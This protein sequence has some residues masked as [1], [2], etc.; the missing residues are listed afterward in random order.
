MISSQENFRF[1]NLHSIWYFF[2]SVCALAP[3]WLRGKIWKRR[4]R[5]HSTSTHTSTQKTGQVMNGGLRSMP[6]GTSRWFP[7]VVDILLV[8]LVHRWHCMGRRW[9]A[10]ERRIG[11]HWRRTLTLRGL[12]QVVDALT[13]GCWTSGGRTAWWQSIWCRW[14][15]NGSMMLAGGEEL[16]L[17]VEFWWRSL[18]PRWLPTKINANKNSTFGREFLSVAPWD[19]DYCIW[20]RGSDVFRWQRWLWPEM[21]WKLRFWIFDRSDAQRRLHSP[22]TEMQLEGLKVTCPS[23]SR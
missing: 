18:T 22:R 13:A 9:C 19:V 21:W 5:R 8:L 10:P 3:K 11:L 12:S 6:G 2:D 15:T 16:E 23:V 7:S 1:K 17:A 14:K 4:S 20:W